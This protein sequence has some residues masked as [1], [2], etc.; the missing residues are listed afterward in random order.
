MLDTLAKILAHHDRKV[1]I[2]GAI[3]FWCGIA[4]YARIVDLPDLPVWF[5][6]AFFWGSVAANA[7]WWSMLYPK[8]AAHKTALNKPDDADG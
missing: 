4:V 6:Q 1:T 2:C 7:I 3:W 8:V 5:R